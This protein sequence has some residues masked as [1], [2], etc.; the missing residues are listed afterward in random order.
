MLK[1]TF[2]NLKHT[3][4]NGFLVA[5][6]FISLFLLF[7]LSID[8]NLGPLDPYLDP[9]ISHLGS[10]IVFGTSLLALAGFAISAI[11]VGQSIQAGN[12]ITLSVKNA[13]VPVIARPPL[14]I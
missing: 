13:K 7:T 9:E 4:I 11:P 1:A 3:V 14:R 8:L 12:G 5:L 6:P 10:F 2:E